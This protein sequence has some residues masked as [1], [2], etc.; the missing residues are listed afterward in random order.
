MRRKLIVTVLVSCAL[1]SLTA[2]GIDR[3]LGLR[4]V[5][6][7]GWVA[8]ESDEQR[9]ADADAVVIATGVKPDGTVDI[10]GFDANAY[11]VTVTESIKGELAPGD[12]IRVG[13][14]ADNCASSEYG[15]GDPM[16]DGETLRL[17]L[18][19]VEGSRADER[20]WRTMTPFD[21]VQ[22]VK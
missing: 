12:T 9:T 14:T 7:A 8:Y 13:S 1:V 16:L 10:M 2:C 11:R 5:A 19:D 20:Q 18:D 17:Y 6:C 22:V 21:G 3:V 15:D 4:G